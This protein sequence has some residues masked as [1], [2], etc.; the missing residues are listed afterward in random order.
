MLLLKKEWRNIMIKQMIMTIM[1]VGVLT[2][3]VSADI[4]IKNCSGCHGDALEKKAMEVSKVVNRMKKEDIIIALK[5][6]QDGSYGGKLK[7]VMKGFAKRLSEEEM[8]A[9]AE[10]FGK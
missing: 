10:K 6:Y 2:V 3:F 9:I 7:A 1:S 8:N 4:N 5:G